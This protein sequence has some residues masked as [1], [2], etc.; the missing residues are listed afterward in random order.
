[1]SC[2]LFLLQSSVSQ[3]TSSQ[4]KQNT[5]GSSKKKQNAW[6]SRKLYP[7]RSKMREANLV[8]YFYFICVSNL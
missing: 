7:I 4:V 3:I 8:S 2:F 1:M 5:K 6:L